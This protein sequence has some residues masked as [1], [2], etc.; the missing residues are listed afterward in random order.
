M[1]DARPLVEFLRWRGER[2]QAIMRTCL[3]VRKDNRIRY[4]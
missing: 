3:G 4:G 1:S 2:E